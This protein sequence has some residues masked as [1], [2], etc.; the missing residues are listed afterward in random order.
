[1]EA[2]GRMDKWV[3][4]QTVGQDEQTC[5]GKKNLSDGLYNFYDVVWITLTRVERT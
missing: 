4:E 3:N 5:D 1:M 2:G